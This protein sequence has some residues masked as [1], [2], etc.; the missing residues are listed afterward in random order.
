MKGTVLSSLSSPSL[1]PA[2]LFSLS[3]TLNLST[4]PHFFSLRCPPALIYPFYLPPVFRCHFSSYSS[5]VAHP[6]VTRF[7]VASGGGR[8]GSGHRT[9][10]KKK[11]EGRS[12]V[13]RPLTTQTLTWWRWSRVVWLAFCG[14]NTCMSH[15]RWRPQTSD[16]LLRNARGGIPS[17]EVIPEGVACSSSTRNTYMKYS[18]RK[19]A[20]HFL[21]AD[22]A[23]RTCRQ[24][25]LSVT[26]VA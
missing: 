8:R 18:A 20:V 9:E 14:T 4:L 13:R 19:V 21:K 23:L 24:L 12:L 5:P 22:D 6:G 3:L 10:K 16:P 2:S 25:E 26:L 7:S 1:S 15:G 17:V 11:I